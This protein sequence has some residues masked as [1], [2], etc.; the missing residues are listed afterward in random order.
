MST[1]ESTLVTE[2]S[3]TS[4]APNVAG[5][6]AYVLGPITGIAFLVLEK[7]NRFV[8]FHAAQSIVVS[9]IMIAVSIVLSIFSAVLAVVPILGWIVALLLSL[10]LALICFALW[11]GLMFTAFSG[12]EWE[13]PVAGQ[14]ARRM[15]ASGTTVSPL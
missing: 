14:F 11:L 8:R 6:L 12:K 9:V 1:P 7:R 2:P 10:G 5:A 13:V 3:S 15:I 4:L